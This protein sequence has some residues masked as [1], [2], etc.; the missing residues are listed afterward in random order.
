MWPAILRHSKVCDDFV[1]VQELRSDNNRSLLWDFWSKLH[2]CEES[3]CC[4]Q[5]LRDHRGLVTMMVGRGYPEKVI[6]PEDG[7]LTTPQAWHE[8]CEDWNI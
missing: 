8:R 5:R 6:L 1:P 4:I 7:H 2:I 3:T